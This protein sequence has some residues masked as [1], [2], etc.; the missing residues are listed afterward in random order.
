M[1]PFLPICSRQIYFMEIKFA[2]R[3]NVW[4]GSTIFYP[5]WVSNFFWVIFRKSRF[6]PGFLIFSKL[7]SFCELFQSFFWTLVV[8]EAFLNFWSF[9]ALSQLFWTSCD[10]KNFFYTFEIFEFF[11]DF[12]DYLSLLCTFLNFKSFR[13]FAK[14]FWN[15]W[16]FSRLLSF[17]KII[18]LF[19]LFFNFLGFLNFLSFVSFLSFL[20]IFLFLIFL[21]F[22]YIF[23]LFLHFELSLNLIYNSNLNLSEI[24]KKF[25]IFS[26]PHKT[27]IKSC[28]L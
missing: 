14:L 21:C 16:A 12:W 8:S 6:F 11:W 25:S 9:K 1:F 20:I 2:F 5:F 22:L 26:W 13:S 3:V 19:E 7:L 10:F 15:F 28:N 27:T 24:N 18:E 17:F 23:E 4:W